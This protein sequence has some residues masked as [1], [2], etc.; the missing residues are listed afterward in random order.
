[1]KKSISIILI[2]AVSILS[3]CDSTSDKE[4]IS[5]QDFKEFYEVSSYGTEEK[6]ISYRM[7]SSHQV[8]KIILTWET[9]YFF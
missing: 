9:Q 6:I 2:F 8:K 5:S 1:M 4:I 3:G 7:S